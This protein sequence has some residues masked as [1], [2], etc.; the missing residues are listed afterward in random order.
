MTQTPGRVSSCL[1]VSIL[2]AFIG[3]LFD[4]SQVLVRGASNVDQGKS[5]N[6]P[7]GLINTREVFLALAV[8]FRYLYFWTFVARRP[9]GEG[10]IT[11]VTPARSEQ[12]QPHSAAWTRW[13]TAGMVLQYLLLAD[14]MGMLSLQ[15]VWR[16]IP[17]YS[18]KGAAYSSAFALEIASSVVFLCKQVVNVAFCPVMPR[19][20]VMKNYIVPSV[21]LFFNIGISVGA[22][23]CCMYLDIL[24]DLLL[25]H[26]LFFSC[27]HRNKFRSLSPSRAV[28][29]ACS[30]HPC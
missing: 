19:V 10:R 21:A 23:D 6:G 3:V 30:V 2:L 7:S 17:A 9:R 14:I 4:L 28:L 16:L 15:L 1:F 18:R 27:L 26:C 13:G 22:L 8:A 11:T 29:S 25:T 5:T 20:G 24:V 12:K